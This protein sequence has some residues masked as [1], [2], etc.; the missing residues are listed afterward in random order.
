M[1]RKQRGWWIGGKL[2]KGKWT[3]ADGTPMDYQ[4]FPILASESFVGSSGARITNY[5]A[6]FKDRGAYNWGYLSPRDVSRMGFIC[7]LD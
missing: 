1:K 6:I 4:N 3:W 2:V 7:E 5:V